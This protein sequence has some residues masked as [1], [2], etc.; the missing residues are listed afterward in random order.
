M[1]GKP[2][3]DLS[4]GQNQTSEQGA[5]AWGLA[6]L[7]S[8][9]SSEVERTLISDIGLPIDYL[10]IRPGATPIAGSSVT[11]TRISAGWRLTRKLF[12]TLSA[13]FCPNDKLLN[14]KALGASLE[15]RFGG[16]WRSS[17]S[18]EPVEA[19]Q[20]ATQPTGLNPTLYQIGVDLLWEKEY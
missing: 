2:A 11:S 20:L 14:Y 1:F 4:G 17:V 8:A 19:C 7:S 5:L 3:F 16:H 9:L 12:I 15:W 10:Q 18:L 6:A 13:G